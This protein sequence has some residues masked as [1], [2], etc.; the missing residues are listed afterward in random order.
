MTGH[1]L[2]GALATVFA[3]H[4]LV[5]YSEARGVFNASDLVLTTFGSPRV[6]DIRFAQLMAR[7]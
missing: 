5:E 3:A 7:V 6:G 2:G 1:S 4:W